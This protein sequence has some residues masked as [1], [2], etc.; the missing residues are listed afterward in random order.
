[1]LGGVQNKGSDSG[2]IKS[3]SLHE[4]IVTCL[5][6]AAMVAIIEELDCK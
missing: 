4:F 6:A 5:T 1:M 3:Y 2:G